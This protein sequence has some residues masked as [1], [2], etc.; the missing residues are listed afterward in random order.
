MIR[1]CIDHEATVNLDVVER[2]LTQKRERRIAG[3][4]VVHRDLE[5]ER[6]DGRQD[7]AHLF[8]A[9]DESRLGDLNLEPMSGKAACRQRSRE[10][11]DKLR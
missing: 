1:H 7:L 11:L 8:A 4:E 6:P 2:E 9:F 5:A 3:P 10:M